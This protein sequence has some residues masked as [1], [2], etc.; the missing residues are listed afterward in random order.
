MRNF[1]PEL[2]KHWGY[3]VE[4]HTVKTEDDYILTMHRI[5]NKNSK[6]YPVIVQHGVLLASDS[7]VLRGPKE[8]LGE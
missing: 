1:Q 8:D 7:W 2:I 3:Q 6:Y 4:N 5:P